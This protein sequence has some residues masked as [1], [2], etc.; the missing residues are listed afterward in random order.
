VIDVRKYAADLL[1]LDRM[2]IK[3]DDKTLSV[4][5]VIAREIVQKYGDNRVYKPALELEKATFTAENAWITEDHPT[6]IIL[7]NPKDIRGKVENPVFDKDRIKAELV[8]LKDRCSPKFLQSIKDGEVRSVSIGFFF[9]LVPESGEFNGERYDY[10]QR[11]ILIDH[12]AVGSWL[13]RCGYPACGI[14]VDRLFT[15]DPWEKTE[16]YIRSGHR[17]PD[18]FV[19]GSLRTIWLSKKEGIK[20]IIGKPKSNPDHTEVQSYLFLKSKGWTIAKAKAW[21]KEHKGDVLADQEE[22]KRERLHETIEART[23]PTN[24]KEKPEGHETAD[25]LICRVKELVAQLK[26]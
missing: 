23:L 2:L 9:D 13:G 14:G 1:E 22:S 20:A 4:P 3:E 16:E 18:E 11:D 17:N 10:V 25:A 19:E 15:V 24:I 5:A 26:A 7:T 8:F 6:E 21:F 12:V